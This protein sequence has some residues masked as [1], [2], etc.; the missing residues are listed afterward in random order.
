METRAGLDGFEEAKNIFPL[1]GF[2]SWI[3][4]L[5]TTQTTLSRADILELQES[6]DFRKG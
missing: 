3:V 1:P 6:F 5:L 4:H 2:E